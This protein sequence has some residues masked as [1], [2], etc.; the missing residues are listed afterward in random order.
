MSKAKAF[1]M[2]ECKDLGL[3]YKM[4]SSLRVTSIKYQKENNLDGLGECLQDY[5]RLSLRISELG[6]KANEINELGAN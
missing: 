1:K 3:L 4:L 5:M 6:G 2:Q